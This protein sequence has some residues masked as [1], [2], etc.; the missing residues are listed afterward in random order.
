MYQST[1]RSTSEEPFLSCSTKQRILHTANFNFHGV[2]IWKPLKNHR[3]HQGPTVIS[4]TEHRHSNTAPWITTRDL[5]PVGQSGSWSAMWCLSDGKVKAIAG[6]WLP[7]WVDTNCVGFR[8]K[9]SPV[10]SPLLAV[11]TKQRNHTGKPWAWK[12]K[13]K[14]QLRA[15][16]TKNISGPNLRCQ[17]Q[18][19]KV[20]D[21]W[22]FLRTR[23]IVQS[24]NSIEAAAQLPASVFTGV[25]VKLHPFKYWGIF[26]P[27]LSCCTQELNV[28]LCCFCLDAISAWLFVLVPVLTFMCVNHCCPLHVQSYHPV[29]RLCLLSHPR[30]WC[31]KR[32]CC[33]QKLVSNCLGKENQK[34]HSP[35]HFQNYAVPEG[36][37]SGNRERRK[38]KPDITA[39][40]VSLYHQDRCCATSSLH[41]KGPCIP[42]CFSHGAFNNVML[43][44]GRETESKGSLRRFL[45]LCVQ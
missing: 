38:T 5:D 42:E 39:Q 4:G 27:D 1:N 15:R 19:I 32:W 45:S 7:A 10:P 17:F 30:P 13:R 40:H 33:L 9:Y 2:L 37:Q 21:S 36:W 35:S 18:Y 23:S 29:L 11:H 24:S 8:Y 26:F 25:L 43:S 3:I 12:Q 44:T 20:R 6:S 14:A 28:K 41:L 22:L 31:K 34:D 16:F